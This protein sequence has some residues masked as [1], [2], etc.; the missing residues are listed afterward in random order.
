MF[1]AFLGYQN[2]RFVCY[3]I[4]ERW[5]WCGMNMI[6][7]ATVKLWFVNSFDNSQ[8]MNI[9]ILCENMNTVNYVIRRHKSNHDV[10]GHVLFKLKC[11]SVQRTHISYMDTFRSVLLVSN[12]SVF[13]LPVWTRCMSYIYNIWQDPIIS[14]IHPYYEFVTICML[15]VCAFVV[16]WGLMD[17]VELTIHTPD[18]YIMSYDLIDYSTSDISSIMITIPSIICR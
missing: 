10:Q 12:I 18:F 15:W 14:E 4:V 5:P 7:H 9:V 16:L 8:A 2:L 13:W 6:N 1:L 17:L 11:S 3:Q